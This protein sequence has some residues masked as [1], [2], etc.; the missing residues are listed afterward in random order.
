ML[1]IERAF[2]N[3]FGADGSNI[4]KCFLLVIFVYYL[5]IG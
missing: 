5:F 1:P 2:T 4:R 3:M